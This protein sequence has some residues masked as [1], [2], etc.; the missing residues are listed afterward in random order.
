MSLEVS[1]KVSKAHTRS[2]HRHKPRPRP[3]LSLCISLARSFCL[4]LSG[5]LS[6][7]PSVL[8]EGIKNQSSWLLLLFQHPA[9]LLPA[10]MIMNQSSETVNKPPIKCLLI[11]ELPCQ[12]ISS[13]Q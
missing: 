10:I 1:F 13:Y 2:R 3:R 9:F 4:C 5:P 7:L 8:L 12:G 11:Y 6:Y